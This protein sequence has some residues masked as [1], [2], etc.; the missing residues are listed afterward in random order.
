MKTFITLLPSLIFVL[1]M[2]TMF[3]IMNKDKIMDKFVRDKF[4]FMEAIEAL[5]SG[6]PIH[7]SGT[8]KIYIKREI[9]CKGKTI[10]EYGNEWSYDEKFSEGVLF[11]LEDVMAEDWIIEEKK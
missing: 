5:E 3:G 1:A 11:K 6:K 9:V 10:V 8:S 7:R 2:S 4:T